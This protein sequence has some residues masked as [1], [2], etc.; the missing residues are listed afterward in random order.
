MRLA[1]GELVEADEVLVA[2]GSLPNTEWLADSG[3]TVGDGLVCD[4]YCEAA[5]ERVRGR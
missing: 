1:D 3:L 5:A 2:I 4:E